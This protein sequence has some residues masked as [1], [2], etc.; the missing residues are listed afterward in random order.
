MIVE[1]LAHV[2]I[3]ASQISKEM[4]QTSRPLLYRR[5]SDRRMPS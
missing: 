2:R 1:T 3:I 5:G 4:G